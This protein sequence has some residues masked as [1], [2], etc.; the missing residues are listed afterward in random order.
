MAAGSV[1]SLEGLQSHLSQPPS[2]T[3]IQIERASALGGRRI[4][5]G[6]VG[7]PPTDLAEDEETSLFFFTGQKNQSVTGLMLVAMG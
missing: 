4:S 3:M 6:P 7:A 1:L 5:K 2:R